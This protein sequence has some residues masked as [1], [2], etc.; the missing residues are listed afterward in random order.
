MPG[1]S[2]ATSWGYHGDD[3]LTFNNDSSKIYAGKKY[4]KGDIVGCLY[5]IE[6]SELSFTLNGT[7]LGEF[8]ITNYYFCNYVSNRYVLQAKHLMM[9][10]GG[11]FQ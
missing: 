2:I 3:G 6:N 5:D 8:F 1:W 7:Y 11:C 10:A 4:G 9:F